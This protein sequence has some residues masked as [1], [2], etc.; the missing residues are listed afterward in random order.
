MTFL[1]AIY[2]NQW[3]NNS[4]HS[5]FQSGVFNKH[6]FANFYVMSIYNVWKP[7]FLVVRCIKYHGGIETYSRV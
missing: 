5:R 3:G 2:D 6:S 1:V 7:L 4:G